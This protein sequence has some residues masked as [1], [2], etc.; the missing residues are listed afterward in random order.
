ML[1]GYVY[2]IVGYPTESHLVGY[3]DRAHI[4]S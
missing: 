3:Y 4:P 1:V 2:T